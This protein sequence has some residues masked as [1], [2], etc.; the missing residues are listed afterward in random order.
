M[1]YTDKESSPSVGEREKVEGEDVPACNIPDLRELLINY[2][3]ELEAARRAFDDAMKTAPDPDVP[4]AQKAEAGINRLRAG[5]LTTMQDLR[6]SEPDNAVVRDTLEDIKELPDHPILEATYKLIHLL[7]RIPPRKRAK[8]EDSPADALSPQSERR[9]S[10]RIKAERGTKGEDPLAK[11]RVLVKRCHADGM[12]HKET[13]DRLGT[14]PRPPRA[15]WRDLTYAQAYRDPKYRS[16]VKT[17]LS[18]MIHQ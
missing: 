11:V 8:P 9:S 6:A 4:R 3:K 5:S 10:T 14:L 7:T 17:A 2:A 1:T 13:C 16:A 15:M 18:K 12:T